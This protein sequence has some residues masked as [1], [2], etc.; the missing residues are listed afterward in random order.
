MECD[1]DSDKTVQPD[2]CMPPVE[3]STSLGLRNGNVRIDFFY[4]KLFSYP[5]LHYRY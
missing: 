2:L 1:N 4:A 5:Q 3:F